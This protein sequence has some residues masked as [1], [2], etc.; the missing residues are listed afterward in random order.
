MHLMMKRADPRIVGHTIDTYKEAK[1][2]GE[3]ADLATDPYVQR[4]I[5]AKEVI[6]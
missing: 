6:E 1:A 4:Y 3:F 2:N 5:A